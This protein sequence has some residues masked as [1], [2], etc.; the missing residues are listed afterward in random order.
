M[1]V[2]ESDARAT[3]MAQPTPKKSIPVTDRLIVA[4]DVESKADAQRVVDELG[5]TVHFYKVGLGLQFRGGIAL[6]T[7]LKERGKKVFLDSKI[8]DVEATTFAA[9][10]SITQLGMDF[11]TVHGN[12][13]ILKEAV[14][15]RGSH[16][17]PKI[18][19]ITVLTSLD[20]EDLVEMGYTVSVD[21]MV[22]YKTESAIKAGVD[23]VITSGLEADLV[24]RLAEKLEYSLLI[25]TPGIRSP[26]VGRDEQ[27]R[28]ATPES[29]IKAGAD[30]IVM[31][32]QILRSK[33]RGDEAK[34]VLEMIDQA[35][36]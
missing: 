27:K 19:A 29:A 3:R 30:Y 12:T 5:D 4:L 10:Q 35:L 20:D 6:A 11:V 8:Y 33:S 15:G 13:S 1:A 25:V 34:R 23:G 2:T 32:R 7:E 36:K 16:Q 9:V 28:V 18:L 24:R 21:K 31:G 14:R 17:N 22:A 26:G